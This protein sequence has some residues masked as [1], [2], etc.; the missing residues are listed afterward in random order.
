MFAFLVLWTFGF[1]YNLDLLQ[2]NFKIMSKS[3]TGKMLE[4]IGIC[5]VFLLWVALGGGDHI[6][7]YRERE[8][9]RERERGGI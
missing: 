9:E 7:I 8:R 5:G 6:Y 2:H 4:N 1:L 3:D